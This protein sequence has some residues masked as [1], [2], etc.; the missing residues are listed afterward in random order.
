M[1][2]T[3]RKEVYRLANT[4]AEGERFRVIDPSGLE[5]DLTTTEELLESVWLP[6]GY[7]RV[8]PITTE[9]KSSAKG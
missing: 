4:K 7:K 8:V 9:D 6:N 2:S 3:V 5:T 1:S